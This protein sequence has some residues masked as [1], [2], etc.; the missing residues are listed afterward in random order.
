MRL[1]EEKGLKLIL[2]SAYSGLDKSVSVA[3][4]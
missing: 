1:D 2:K 3:P 4:V